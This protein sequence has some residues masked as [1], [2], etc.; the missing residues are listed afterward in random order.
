M[1]SLFTGML[2]V[3]LQTIDGQVLAACQIP[4]FKSQ[5]PR[6]NVNATLIPTIINFALLSFEVPADIQ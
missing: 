1:S 6:E 4:V 5:I 3:G 2:T